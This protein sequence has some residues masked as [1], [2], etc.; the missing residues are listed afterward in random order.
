MQSRCGSAHGCHELS[1]DGCV[2]IRVSGNPLSV[3]IVIRGVFTAML[4]SFMSSVSRADR[5]TLEMGR[6]SCSD[7]REASG[8]LEESRRSVDGPGREVP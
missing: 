8:G 3:V 7:S 1:G 4:L 2:A 5:A 6:S